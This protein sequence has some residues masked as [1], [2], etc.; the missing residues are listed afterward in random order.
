MVARICSD[1][2]VTLKGIFDLIPCFMASLAMLAHRPMSSY[3]LLVHDPINPTLIS[4]GQLF[5]F[6]F[7]PNLLIGLAKSGVNGPLTCGS[8][9]SRLISITW[10]YLAS[11][12]KL[13]NLNDSIPYMLHVPS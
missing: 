8:R 12:D 1:P 3:E 4:T 2:G 9:V 11:K 10:S 7:S 6:A 13:N 5:F